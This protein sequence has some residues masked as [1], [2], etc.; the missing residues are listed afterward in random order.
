M[1]NRG[2]VTNVLKEHFFHRFDIDDN[3][4]DF[5]FSSKGIFSAFCHSISQFTQNIYGYS[6]KGRQEAKH[7]V[8]RHLC[9]V[10]RNAFCEI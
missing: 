7:F 10:L 9:I 8:R 6:L 2:S 1:V 3:N 5:V 4:N